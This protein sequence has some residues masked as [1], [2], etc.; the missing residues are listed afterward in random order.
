MRYSDI[1]DIES[2]DNARRILSRRI[3]RKGEEVL[4]RW[5]EMKEAYSPMGL[6]ASGIRSISGSIPFDKIILYGLRF[7]RKRFI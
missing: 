7:I 1:K 6:L 5:G 2:L 4:D 3:E